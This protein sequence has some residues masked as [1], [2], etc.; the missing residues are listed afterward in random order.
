[1]IA[2]QAIYDALE[3]MTVQAINDALDEWMSVRKRSSF[4]AVFGHDPDRDGFLLRVFLR[5][6]PKRVAYV[7]VDLN[8][9]DDMKH[10]IDTIIDAVDLGIRMLTPDLPDTDSPQTAGTYR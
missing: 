1:M 8:P 5:E 9:H 7:P 6:R 10:R 4:R 2:D 3:D